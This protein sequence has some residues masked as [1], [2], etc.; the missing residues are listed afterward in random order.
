LTNTQPANDIKIESGIKKGC[1]ISGILF[2]IAIDPI[3]RNIQGDDNE[4]KILAYAD[5]LVI[6]ANQK[7]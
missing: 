7:R 3:I 4:Q 1:P 2:N 6:P 5:D